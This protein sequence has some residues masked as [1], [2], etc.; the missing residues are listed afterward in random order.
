MAHFLRATLAFNESWG[1]GVTYYHPLILS[2]LTRGKWLWASSSHVSIY[3]LTWKP[4][5]T[6]LT[7]FVS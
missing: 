5:C 7:W 2:G 1:S 4:I 6:N 3:H